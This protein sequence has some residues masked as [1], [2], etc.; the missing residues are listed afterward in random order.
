MLHSHTDNEDTIDRYVR[1]RL[2]PEERQSF[3]E[4]FFSCEQCFRAVQDAERFRAGI[5]DAARRGLL[6]DAS[7]DALKLGRPTWFQWAL[8]L[9]ACASL[10][11]A[12]IIGWTHLREIPSLRQEVQR[13]AAQLQAERRAR[14]DLEQRIASAEQAEANVPLVMLDAS[15]A[16]ER[17][18]AVALPQTAKRL[19]VWMEIGPTRYRTFRMEVFSPGG[20]LVA[21]LDHLEHGAY[22]ALAASLPA[23]QLPTG[24][25]RI[26]L[27]GQNPPPASLIGE[28]RLR[29][30]RH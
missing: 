13:T 3:E 30:E 6:R 18:Q 14:T 11:L 28:Y 1:G 29:V 17:S 22:D 8:A 21:S 2:T 26:T 15:R 20:H 10:G 24:N 7:E 27:T 9:T 25:L 4:H 16:A 12:V 5:R 23:D 19:I